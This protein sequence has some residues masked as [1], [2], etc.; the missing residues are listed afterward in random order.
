LS[1]IFDSISEPIARRVTA[2][3]A[4]IGLVLRSRAWKG[5]GTAGV[6]PTQGHALGLLRDAPDGMRLAALAKLLGISAPTASDAMN[7]LVAKG[8]VA[9]MPGADRRSISLVLTAEGEGA[10]DRTREW[11]GFLAE[12]VD[13]LPPDEQAGLL[14]GLVKVIRALQVKGDIPPQRMCVSCHYFRPCA[15]ED[16]LNPHHCA[17]VDAAFGDRHL[18]LN[19]G[20]HQIASADEQEVHWRRFAGPTEG[21][22]FVEG[23][24]H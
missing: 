4:K 17:Y 24:A 14:R 10:A 21:A 11:P 15:H 13:T 1:A 3:L 8:L 22:D 16:R 23:G 5:A 20:E 12:A 6:T 18:R 19:C 7:A 2:G 9:K